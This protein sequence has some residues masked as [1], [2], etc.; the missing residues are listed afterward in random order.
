MFDS[1][2]HE[3]GLQRRRR[4][5][6]STMPTYV[7]LG[8]DELAALK[9]RLEREHAEI[10]AAGG[11]VPQH[12]AR[13]AGQGAAR[14]QHAAARNDNHARRLRVDRTAPTAATYGVVDGLPEAKALMA[15]MLDDDP[16][17]RH[18]VRQC[19]PQHHVRRPGSLLVVRNARQHPVE[20]ARN[21]ALD[22]PRPR[23]RPPLRGDRGLRH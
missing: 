4:G 17:K 21:R 19:Q 10:K 3:A 13:Q 20:Q 23:L 22:L 5:K 1:G 8:N 9:D 2:P 15:S 12:G 16:E 11:P 14:P 18:R 6:G 7:E